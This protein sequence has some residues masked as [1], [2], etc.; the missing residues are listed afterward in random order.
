MSVQTS[1]CLSPSFTSLVITFL[2]KKKYYVLDNLSQCW[3]INLSLQV[4][5][6]TEHCSQQQSPH[7]GRHRRVRHHSTG[8]GHRNSYSPC[9]CLRAV[10]FARVNNFFSLKN[11][12]DG[13]LFSFFF[14]CVVS[15]PEH[16]EPWTLP[17]LPTVFV[18]RLTL[19]L[20]L[21]STNTNIFFSGYPIPWKP[22][23]PL[24]RILRIL[25]FSTPCVPVKNKPGF[26]CR[27]QAEAA[28]EPQEAQMGWSH[29][30]SASNGCNRDTSSSAVNNTKWTLTNAARRIYR[31][32]VSSP[33]QA[34]CEA[35]GHGAGLRYPTGYLHQHH[36]SG[37]F[38]HSLRPC[39]SCTGPA[40]SY[41]LL[42]EHQGGV[43][44]HP[45]LF[46]G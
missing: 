19:M 5:S 1:G 21:F 33:G 15:I 40:G 24:V 37:E 34:G 14:C 4:V 6:Q 43:R 20:T 45:Q 16:Q 39:H 26:L 25:D 28:V 3:H 23:F 27:C 8:E 7:L 30:H 41:L 44:V 42:W 32:W 31:S 38:V 22:S 9:F 13:I 12:P 18:P 17:Q 2:E 10:R 35:Q 46:L 36:G 11:N 29:W